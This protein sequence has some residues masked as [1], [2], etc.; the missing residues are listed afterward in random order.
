MRILAL[1]YHYPPDAGSGTHR[2]LH[3]LNR[4]AAAGDEVTVVTSREE[5]FTVGT[6]ADPELLSQ[7]EPGIRILRA[8]ALRPLYFLL[9][10]RQWVRGRG[11][12]LPPAAFAAASNRSPQ[13]AVGRVQ[14]IKD[15]ITHALTFPDEHVGWIPDALRKAHHAIRL[16]APECIY[17]SGGPW[18]S[19]I[20]AVLLKKTHGLPLVLDFRDPWASNPFQVTGRGRGMQ[21]LERKLEAYCVTSADQIITNTEPLRQDFVRRYRKEPESKFTTVTN[22]FENVLMYQKD[23]VGSVF[24]LVHAGELYPPRTPA[25]FLRAILQMLRRGEIAPTELRV[26]F[27]GHCSG[28]ADVQELLATQELRDLVEVTPRVPHSVALRYQ[29]DADVLLLFQNGFPLQVPRKLFE[30][31]SMRK[32]VLAIANRGSATATIVQ[33]AGIGVLAE[34]DVESITLAL[35]QL[36]HDW[37]GGTRWSFDLDRILGF[38]NDRLAM[39]LRAVLRGASEAHPA[40]VMGASDA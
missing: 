33:E 29:L 37:R 4:L 16:H 18:S 32:P 35:L 11:T 31:M 22:G 8:A 21:A 12:S 6:P 9:R 5:D 1:A 38:R 7:V 34:D 14:A 3:L 13:S 10:C 36:Y 20:A 23:G 40:R 19:H 17:S 24:T 27:V 39:Q 25:C 15:V 30:Y 2:S 28:Q 26:R